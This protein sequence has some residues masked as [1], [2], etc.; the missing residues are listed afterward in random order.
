[1]VQ[2]ADQKAE[3]PAVR[4]HGIETLTH[5]E[6]QRELAAGS[7]FVFFEY[8]IS[9]IF[10]TLRR[11]SNVYFLRA[12]E[13]AFLRS[14]PYC[15]ISLFLGWW[16]LPWG[17]IY[18]PLTIILNLSGGCDVTCQMREFLGLTEDITPALQSAAS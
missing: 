3:T 16:G 5:E 2:I 8:T 6:L 9:L 11:P 15:L 7:R 10:L 13:T 18:T 1:M 17:I 14:L 12:R 4:I